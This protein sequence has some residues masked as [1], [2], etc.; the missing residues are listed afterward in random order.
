MPIRALATAATVVVLALTAA[1]ALARARFTRTVVPYR[2]IAGVTLK[3]TPAQIRARFGKPDAVFHESGKISG[4][5]YN[6]IEMQIDFDIQSQ[7]DGATLISADDPHLHSIRGIRI[8]TSIR[9]VRA[10]LKGYKSLTCS[11]G[12]GCSIS[13][14]EAGA[15]GSADT[16]FS[17][18]N[19]KVSGF[20][21]GY[22]FNDN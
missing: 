20:V 8:G 1:P 6:A 10:R 21:V 3:S 14:G 12:L 18:S 13:R 19:G 2:S 11:K 9:T 16:S 15:P 4:Y 17:T 22:T 7:T 5:Q